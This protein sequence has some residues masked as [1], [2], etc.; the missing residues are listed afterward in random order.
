M[1]L[2]CLRR[3]LNCTLHRK[4]IEWIE[5]LVRVAEIAIDKLDVS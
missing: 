1:K 3:C 5:N 2:Y 4:P